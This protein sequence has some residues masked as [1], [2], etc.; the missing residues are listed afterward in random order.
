[1]LFCDNK[2]PHFE[3]CLEFRN[4]SIEKLYYIRGNF[5]IITHD[6][7]LYYF[8]SKTAHELENSYETNIALDYQIINDTECNHNKEEYECISSEVTDCLFIEKDGSLFYQKD[9]ELY[10]ISFHL[11]SQTIY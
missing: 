8:Y 1:M 11:D 7:H 6:K 2:N 9:E 3:L 5:F 4:L 10:F